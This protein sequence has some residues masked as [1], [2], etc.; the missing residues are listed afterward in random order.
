[1]SLF[2]ARS[3]RRPIERR[4]NIPFGQHRVIDGGTY[5]DVSA[6]TMEGALR[7]IAVQVAA[8]VIASIGSEL[9][10]SV[11]SGIGSDR[12]KQKMPRYLQ[13]PAGDGNGLEDW[14]YQ[15]LLCW[16][17]RGNAI[18]DVLDTDRTGRPM[19]VLWQHPDEVGGWLR[20]DGSVQWTFA[21]HVVEDERRVF[22]R[23][24]NPVPGRVLGLSVVQTHITD[25][26]LSLTTT[27]F[28]LQFLRDGAHPTGILVNEERQLTRDQALTA[29]QR[30]VAGLRGT[31]EPA[32]MD[33]GWKYQRI[34]ISPEES[35]FLETRKLSEADCARMFGPGMP[36]MLGYATGD[37][38][39]YANRVD[40]LADLLVLS[41]NRWLKRLERMI[42]DMLPDPQ[43][44]EI[45]RSGLLEATLIERYRAY[46]LALRGQPW[47]AANEIRDREG[48]K[49]VPWGD[50][51][52]AS[53]GPTPSID[54][55][56]EDDQK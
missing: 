23:R 1:M 5:A 18:G 15:A 19:Q 24:V 36:E 30:F 16:L 21:G 27:Q 17:I 56:K 12:I 29:K 35:Q 51:P 11:Y 8:D 2:Y 50:E 42:T 10:I 53:T 47:I 7:S 3:A 44:A 20:P 33:R 6:S 14:C 9:P 38:M 32:V 43:Y 4:E 46:A 49:S 41:V 34:Q 22:H 26:T 28:G 31:R 25:V 52:I 37:S 39:T 54:P 48:L 55:S 40:R 13:D 45:D